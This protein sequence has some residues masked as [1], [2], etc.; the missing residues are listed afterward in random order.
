MADFWVL[1]SVS[2]SSGIMLE[3]FPGSRSFAS[4][5]HRDNSKYINTN[6]N[7]LVTSQAP[8]SNMEK[9]NENKNIMDLF[10]QHFFKRTFSKLNVSP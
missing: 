7:N 5:V 1:R 6:D 9:I 2:Y 10:K 3:Y 8:D 4:R